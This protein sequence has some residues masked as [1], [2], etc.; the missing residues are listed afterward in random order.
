VYR[1]GEEV[2]VRALVRGE[3]F[4]LPPEKMPVRMQ[5]RRPDGRAWQ[6]VTAALDAEGALSWKAAFPADAQTGYWTAAVTM[7]AAAGETP[8]VLGDM[9]FQIEEFLPDRIKTA[10]SAEGLAAGERFHIGDEP[11]K[12]AVQSD[13][14]FGQPAAGLAAAVRVRIAPGMFAAP[15]GFVAGDKARAGE[16]LAEQKR[17]LPVTVEM[18]KVLDAKGH[19]VAEVDLG[20]KLAAYLP[21][22]KADGAGGGDVDLAEAYTFRGPWQVTATESTTEVSGRAVTAVATV[23]ADGLP[24]Y[25]CVRPEAA[26]FAPGARAGFDVRVLSPDGAAAAGEHEIKAAVYRESWS[27]HLVEQRGR[28]SYESTRN[29]DRVESAAGTVRA[30][31]AG[32]RFEWTPHAS[33]Q[34]VLELIDEATAQA[35]TVRFAVGD[36]SG[37]SDSLARDN[38]EGLEVRLLPAGASVED[39][40]GKALFH[41]GEE[42]KAL[43][44]APFAGTLLLTV[45]S[46]RVLAS[47]VVGL[48]TNGA[49]VPMTL[50]AHLPPNAF[51]GATVVRA[52]EANKEWRTHR[53]YGVAR[54]NVDPSPHR[55][56]VAL[57]AP[58]ELRPDTTLDVDVAVTDASG[59][60]TKDA[61]VVLFAVD[62]GILRLTDFHTP[63]PLAYFTGP[64][65]LGVETSDLYDR[66][67]PEVPKPE[68]LAQVGGDAEEALRSSP[69]RAQRVKPVALATEVLQTDSAGAAHAHL[70]VPRFLGNLRLMAVTYQGE[71]VGMGQGQ[72]LVRSPLIVQ[73]SFPRFLAPGDTSDLP[74][75]LINNSEAAGDVKLTLTVDNGELLEVKAPETTVH[76]EAHGQKAVMVRVEAKAAAGVAHLHLGAV[77]N[78]E[79]WQ[80]TVELPVRPPSPRVTQGQTLVATPEQPVTFTP[81]ADVLPGT[82][83]LDVRVS[84]RPQLSLPEALDYLDHYPYGCLEQTTSTCLPLVYLPEIGKQVAPDLF[85]EARTG[86]KVQAGIVRLLS[87]QTAGGGLAMWPGETSPWAFGSV[88]AAQ[89]LVEAEAAGQPVPE[90]FKASLLGYLRTLLQRSPETADAVETQAYAAYVLAL[91]GRPDRPAMNRLGEIVAAEKSAPATAPLYLALAQA[92]AGRPEAAAGLLPQEL[93]A[94][95][96]RRELAGNLASP[97]SD[98]ALLLT[99]L[100]TIQPNHP[101][102]PALAQKLADGAQARG[103]GGWMSTHDNALAFLA[104]GK[105]LRSIKDE[106][107]F[108]RSVLAAG[109]GGAALLT[110]LPGTPGA[111]SAKEA[112]KGP[113]T[114]TVE[115]PAKAKAFVSWI[116]TGVP[117]HVPPPADHHLQVRRTFLTE[118]DKAIEG[119]TLA[120]GTAV[121]VRLTLKAPSDLQNVVLEELLPAGLEIEK[122]RLETTENTDGESE[123]ERHRADGPV[124]LSPARVDMRDDRLVLVTDLLAGESTFTYLAR[125][126]T[127]GTYVVPPV[128]AECMYDPS[129]NSMADGGG[130]LTVTAAGRK[131]IAQR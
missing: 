58:V 20:E 119:T 18:P 104:L 66:L 46:D 23:A 55:L 36:T 113:L 7:S 34:Y 124:A 86:R 85:D 112:M 51:I 2:T 45:E 79:A 90:D 38:P 78:G 108:T 39:K 128:H 70:H 122:P 50:P 40:E 69:V 3:D 13:Y 21:P 10:V 25:V 24:Y 126:V 1:P 53:A 6:T 75:L 49:E 59:Q 118:K 73:S 117:L 11:L 52:V 115:G 81:P 106:A 54:F 72:T 87:M 67:M 102:I 22:E 88:Y 82:G 107:P 16:V 9:H 28:F 131:A 94:P 37:W 114:L 4:A 68:A 91:A 89:F 8:K 64:R 97:V 14:L 101:A 130:T 44:R 30:G 116:Q 121:K 60:G 125:A 48:K 5:L 129:I 31:E 103:N 29:L 100:L 98:Q 17:P 33:G 93:P 92:A 76:L 111:W 99:T 84:P 41:P 63:D 57:K 61:S 127:P 105:Y 83:S 19:A 74:M 71:R 42:A 15:E 96:D 80:E 95:R 120:T 47:Q 109:D 35:T 123:R 65:A 26:A 77:M 110:V 62:E 43:V 12:L 32:G 27:T 56:N